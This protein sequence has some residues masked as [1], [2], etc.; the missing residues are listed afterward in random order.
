[1]KGIT[2]REM[3]KAFPVIKR[4]LW[5][6]EFW[7]DGYSVR[8]VSDKVTEEIIRKYIE[9]HYKAIGHE[10]PQQLELF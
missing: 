5:G 7:E 2:A 4:D 1:M 8:S 6:G 9:R 3:F 10:P